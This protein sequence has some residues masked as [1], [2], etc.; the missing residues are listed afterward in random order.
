LS[1]NQAPARAA[2]ERPDRELPGGHAV[3]GSVS[4][5][6]LTLTLLWPL[7][8]AAQSPPEQR[9]IISVSGVGEVSA[10]PDLVVLAV[11]VETTAARAGDAVTENAN[12][13]AKVAAALRALLGKQDKLTTTSYAVEPRYDAGKRGEP[14]EA[15]IIGYVARNEVQVELHE[16]DAVGGLIDAATNAGA[17]R[18]SNL[19]FTLANRNEQLRAALQKAAGEARAQA[20]SVAAA[21]GVTLKQLVAASTS[22]GPILPRRFDLGMAAAEMRAPTP[23]EP[24]SVSVTATLQVTYEIE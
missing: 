6:L 1:V 14:G 23:I 17:N 15:R 10:A 11:A 7:A 4:L 3:R 2:G 16:I 24:G 13:S 9:R 5:A 22:T 8:G 21:L 19:Q 12:R 20:E 18:I